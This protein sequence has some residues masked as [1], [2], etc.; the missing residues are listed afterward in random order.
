MVDLHSLGAIST[1]LSD[2]LVE[3]PCRIPEASLSRDLKTLEQRSRCEG[4]G[5][6]CRTL[7]SLGKA[8][9]S[10]LET[11]QLSVPTG[12]RSSKRSPGLP[13]F[14]QDAFAHVFEA[15]GVLRSDD[16][17]RISLAVGFI[18]QVTLFA[19]KL[20]LPYDPTTISKFSDTYLDEDEMVAEGLGEL[21]SSDQLLQV[22]AYEVR[23]L[24]GDGPA[25]FS[26]PQ[27]GPGAVADGSRNERKYEFSYLSPVT[28]AVFGDRWFYVNDR[29]RQDQPHGW[30]LK[31][32]SAKV[33]FVNKD[34]RGPRV[35]AKEP[36]ENQWLQQMLRKTMC[37][38]IERRSDRRIN[39][40]DQRINGLLALSSSKDRRF[41]TMDM[42]SASDLVGWSHAEALLPPRWLFLL[43]GCRTATA[44]LPDGR[45]RFLKKFSSMGSATTFPLEALVFWSLA[46]AAISL[47]LPGRRRWIRR[48]VYAYGDD[49]I[50]PREYMGVVADAL[51]RYGL[52]VNLSKSFANGHFRESCG[53]DAYYGV[54]VSPVR[55]RHLLPMSR[56]DA[57]RL[58]SVVALGR[59]LSAKGYARAAE[60]CFGYAE[61]VLGCSLP[62][63]SDDAG[64][65]CRPAKC[66]TSALLLSKKHGSRVRFHPQYHRWE[67][68]CS[69]PKVPERAIQLDG[70]AR[71]L[72]N[73]T[74]GTGDRP[75]VT[76]PYR[77]AVILRTKWRPA[78]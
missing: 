49:I 44:A 14:M 4:F 15:D 42:K 53:V 38:V 6:I 1:L 36:K 57:S 70:W 28:R 75:D 69:A 29:H 52:K 51:H 7:P 56:R 8:L 18:R 59:L 76:T 43:S 63:G 2:L 9:E 22:A 54:N 23:R 39:F 72:R 45:K 37:P 27:H 33:L 67:V 21:K 40:V 10:A 5:F 34:S 13:A 20:E 61:A 25:E 66:P 35:I 3:N 48:H 30:R 41:A 60:R 73:L 31:H 58:A 24:L 19:Y 12:F 74:Q 26:L 71:L 65:L 55:V 64:Y 32:V 17:D 47:V 16:H 11:G 50:V 68:L 62:F 77:G 46:V 78:Q